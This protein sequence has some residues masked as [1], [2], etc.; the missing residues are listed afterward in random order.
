MN[1]SHHCLIRRIFCSVTKKNEKRKKSYQKFVFLHIFLGICIL[2]VKYYV[3]NIICFVR[4]KQI[5]VSV[6][7]KAFLEVSV[8]ETTKKKKNKRKFKME[9]KY[10]DICALAVT[11]V[12]TCLFIS[13]VFLSGVYC[14]KSTSKTLSQCT[15][16]KWHCMQKSNKFI[17]ISHFTYNGNKFSNN[18]KQR[19][20]KKILCNRKTI[21]KS[22]HHKN[23]KKKVLNI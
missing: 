19:K 6:C 22:Q 8:R 21:A 18:K 2:V 7:Q 15:N 17:I 1:K 13:I 14:A 9:C 3:V 20:L 5:Y 10:E 12:L 11:N 23:R 16:V 4:K